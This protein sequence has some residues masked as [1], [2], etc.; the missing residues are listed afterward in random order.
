M[1]Q[2]FLGLTVAAAILTGHALYNAYYNPKATLRDFNY[3]FNLWRSI[4]NH[5]GYSSLEEERYRMMVWI[6]NLHEIEKHNQ[7]EK[8]SYKMGMNKFGDFTTEEFVKKYTGLNI[9]KL[10]NSLKA[11]KSVKLQAKP[12]MDSIDWADMGKVT[13]VKNQGLCSA[14]WAFSTTAALES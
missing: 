4:N 5:P 14:G 8:I 13:S 11:K 3:E 12:S 10:K 1:K 2:L 7:T 9:K 6:N